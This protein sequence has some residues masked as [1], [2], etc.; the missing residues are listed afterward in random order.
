[1]SWWFLRC[2]RVSELKFHSGKLLQGS[3]HVVSGNGSQN[4][5]PISLLE[6]TR[7]TRSVR[8]AYRNTDAAAMIRFPSPRYEMDTRYLHFRFTGDSPAFL[9]DLSCSS[10]L[11]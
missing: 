3:S 6:S 4:S 7:S 10:A 8:S 9:P 11:E 2:G 5:S 1:M